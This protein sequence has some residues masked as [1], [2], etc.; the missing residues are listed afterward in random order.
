MGKKTTTQTN[1]FDWKT[2]PETEAYKDFA[3]WKPDTRLLDESLGYQYQSAARDLDTTYNSPW[4]GLNNP[5]L[6]ATLR[7]RA[8]QNL[9]EQESTAKRGGQQDVNRLELARREALARLAAPQLVQS[10]GQT[11][12]KGNFWDYMQPILAAGAGGVASAAR[13]GA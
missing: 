4:S 8:Q 12:Q 2:P 9:N 5:V 3:A 10:G 13:F 1:T 11:V 7:S 6:A